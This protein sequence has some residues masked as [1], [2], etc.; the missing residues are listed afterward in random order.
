MFVFGGAPACS[1]IGN[2][3]TEGSGVTLCPVEDRD[4]G[5]RI[6]CSY[7]MGFPHVLSPARNAQARPSLQTWVFHRAISALRH[8]SLDLTAFRDRAICICPENRTAAG[9]AS[10][11]KDARMQGSH[12]SDHGCVPSGPGRSCS[13]LFWG[14]ISEYCFLV[15]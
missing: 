6:T 13:E 11:L 9:V 3:R 7:L 8:F 5:H 12:G 10:L 2:I 14:R 4:T 1:I 15:G